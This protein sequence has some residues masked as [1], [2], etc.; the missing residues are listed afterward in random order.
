MRPFAAT[1]PLGEARSILDGAVRSI[2][3]AESVG[4]SALTGRVLAEH[5]TADADVPPFARAMMDG[6]ALRAADTTGASR[7]TPRDLRV[8]GR[9]FT[10][11]VFAGAVAAGQAVEIA[12]GAPLPAGADAVVMVEE[13][14]P[15]G[16]DRVAIT[17]AATAGHHVGRAGADIAR[18]ATVLHAGDVL[19]PSRVG[20]LAALGRTEAR[21]LARPRVA[22]VSTG[23]EIVAPGRPLGPGQIYDINRHTLS[24]VIA[25]HGGVAE[26]L[27]VAGDTMDALDRALDA[28][29]ACDLVVFSGGSSVGDRDLVLDVLRRRGEVLF[30]GIATRPGK[31]TAF[32]RLGDVP[33][34]GMP[35]N[36]TS[37]LTNAYVLLVPFL[38]RLAGLPPHRP[39][40]VPAP[41]AR[42]VTSGAGRHQFYTVRLV[43]GRA[44]PAFKASSDITSMA[45]ADGYIEIAAEVTAIEAGTTVAVVLF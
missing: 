5:V 6:Y 8:V 45:Q 21:V 25:G 14:R 15:A 3:R 40:V 41:L 22:I 28:A 38:R 33:V 29:V 42:R 26:P 19:A 18:G 30:H 4:L 27:E 13:T 36:P 2:V 34:F 35:G 11:E 20:V 9:V 12:T 7:E 17:A 10:G 31:P 1:I 24:A 32:G 16:A 44:E 23:N 43:D 37:C 39:H